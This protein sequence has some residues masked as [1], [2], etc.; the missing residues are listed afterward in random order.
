VIYIDS[1]VVLAHLFAEDRAP[2]ASIWQQALIASRLLEYEVCTR[3]HARGLARSHGADAASLMARISLVELSPAVLARALDAFPM[4]LRTL[5]ALHLATLE[6]LR[7]RGR[8]IALASYD[9][10]LLAVARSLAVPLFDA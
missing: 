9:E 10:R 2:P 7:S 4:P 5:D 6:F 1:S 8:D 3:V